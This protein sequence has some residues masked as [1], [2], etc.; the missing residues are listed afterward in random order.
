MAIRESTEK[1]KT[2]IEKRYFI[3]SIGAYTKL[4]A[5]PVRNYSDIEI[6]YWL[7]VDIVLKED[8]SR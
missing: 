8:A 6:T 7:L 2:T 5:K 1:D 4:F 3:C